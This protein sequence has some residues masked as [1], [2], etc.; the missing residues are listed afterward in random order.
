MDPETAKQ[1]AERYGIVPGPVVQ[2]EPLPPAP[3]Q[4]AA[5]PPP[6]TEQPAVPPGETPPP[7]VANEIA[8]VTLVCRAV[9]LTSVVASGNTEL[10]FVFLNE[11]KTSPLFDPEGT[12]FAGNINP[13]EPPGTFTFPVTL[14]LKRPL[15]L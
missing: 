13:D 5:P 4:Q 12:Q 3:V 10:A 14:K 9:S 11:L 6:G 8:T 15:K 1:Y 7:A 2:A